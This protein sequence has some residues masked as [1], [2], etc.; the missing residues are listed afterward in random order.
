MIATTAEHEDPNPTYERTI[1]SCCS[2]P[3]TRNFFKPMKARG[4]L[5]LANIWRTNFENCAQ[6]ER[7]LKQ[8]T[9]YTKYTLTSSSR[10]IGWLT[11]DFVGIR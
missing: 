5:T 3:T 6:P 2:G 1:P 10:Y 8:E 11:T 7:S 4:K 9:Y